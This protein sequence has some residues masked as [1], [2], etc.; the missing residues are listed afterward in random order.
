M[1][2]SISMDSFLKLTNVNIIDIRSNQAYNNNHIPGAINIPYE[3]LIVGPSNYLSF[4][5]IYYIYCQKGYS[6]L[7][8]SN[9]LNKMGYKTLSISGGYEEWIMKK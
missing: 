4:G 2:N 3:R 5:K 7:K 6:S 8:I 1:Q 9:I